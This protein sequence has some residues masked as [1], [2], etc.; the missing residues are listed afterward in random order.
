VFT[1]YVDTETNNYIADHVGRCDREDNCGY[2]YTPSD[3]KKDGG[4]LPDK[5]NHKSVL[6]PEYVT[7]PEHIWLQTQKEPYESENF[8]KWLL[9]YFGGDTLVIDILKKYKVGIME[10]WDTPSVVF[11]SVSKE[12]KYYS[13]KIMAYDVNGKRQKGLVGSVHAEMAGLKLI[14]KDYQIKQCF[15]G[16]HLLNENQKSVM[17]VESEKTAIFCA[18][19]WPDFVWLATSSMNGLSPGK[20]KTLS[21]KN[22]VLIP[23]IGKGVEVWRAKLDY[24][25][26]YASSV[27][28]SEV[29]LKNNIPAMAGLDIVDL[30]VMQK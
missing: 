19:K 4:K 20:I 17:I 9:D 18:I 29:I 1:R 2:H 14:P 23:D 10:K 13:G 7:I 8:C 15:F 26:C 21:G 5:V 16:A 6:P 25:K 24:I 22:V 3:Y 28:M 12:Y 11:W 27:K 30:I